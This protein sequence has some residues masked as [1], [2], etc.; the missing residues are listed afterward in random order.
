MMLESERHRLKYEHL[1][2]VN[3]ELIKEVEALKSKA[4]QM[5]IKEKYKS[6]ISSL[7][8]D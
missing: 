6:R 5:T 2:K 4:H 7:F 8:D 3:G 1:L